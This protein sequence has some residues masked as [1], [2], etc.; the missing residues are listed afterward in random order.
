MLL[1]LAATLAP[2][3]L[4]P[5]GPTDLLTPA[6]VQA[7]G[8]PFAV[9]EGTDRD[10]HRILFRTEGD[11]ITI[12]RL[13]CLVDCINGSSSACTDCS[14]P[15]RDDF[16]VA[17]V[18]S[19]DQ[20]FTATNLRW[21]PT[22]RVLYVCGGDHGLFRLSEGA[23][24]WSLA[25]V[26][27]EP[28]TVP[29]RS[30]SL[31]CFDVDVS[32]DLVVA[33]YAG[34][35]RSVLRAY[36]QPKLLG[37]SWD[38][39]APILAREVPLGGDAFAPGGTAYAVEA[40]GQYAYVGLG[41]GGIARV[42]LRSGVVEPGPRGVGP[43][44]KIRD[45]SLAGHHLYAAAERSTG[46]GLLE[47]DLTQAWGPDMAVLSHGGEDVD[48]CAGDRQSAPYFCRVEAR[49]FPGTSDVIIA[50]A[51]H[52]R[53]V[54][55][56]EGGPYTG[57]GGFDWDL[58]V[59]GPPD[60]VQSPDV[61]ESRLYLFQRTSSGF[62]LEDVFVECEF[63]AMIPSGCPGKQL[64]F[65]LRDLLL[66]TFE[67]PQGLHRVLLMDERVHAFWARRLFGQEAFSDLVPALPPETFFTH[68]V[69]F[70]KGVASLVNP[71]VFLVGRDGGPA[72]Y[73][74]PRF[75]G[76]DAAGEPVLT[77]VEGS[78]VGPFAEDFDTDPYD[79]T[80]GLRLGVNEGAQWMD[81]R[82]GTDPVWANVE[83]H[84]GGSGTNF[85]PQWGQPE[86]VPT[87]KVTRLRASRDPL[88]PDVPADDSVLMSTLDWWLLPIPEDLWSVPPFVTPDPSCAGNPSDWTNPRGRSYS[89]FC[90]DPRPESTLFFAGRQGVPH[91]MVVLDSARIVEEV[92]R[93]QIES[94]FPGLGSG[95]E[96][97]RFDPNGLKGE[98]L[99]GAR[100]V[101]GGPAPPVQRST[102]DT[103]CWSGGQPGALA[104]I[105]R[106][107]VYYVCGGYQLPQL[108]T[109]PEVEY[110]LGQTRDIRTSCQAIG[111][112]TLQLPD[113]SGTIR[114][115]LAVASAFN[116]APERVDASG[117]LVPNELYQ[118]AQYTLFDITDWPT[119]GAP[120][121]A[122]PHVI[123]SP[124]AQGY[125]FDVGVARLDD[126]A[127]GT[128]TIL[129]GCDS[130]AGRVLA[131]DVTDLPAHFGDPTWS[132]PLAGQ[133]RV[134]P[135]VFDDLCDLPVDIA[136]D[137]D[138]STG[139]T[140]T[141]AYV[142][143]SRLG[144][145]ALELSYEPAQQRVRMDHVVTVNTPGQAVQLLIQ[146]TPQGKRA[147]LTDHEGLG[148]R[149][150][151]E[152]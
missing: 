80:N 85:Q 20:P 95:P 81:P 21:E 141:Y 5:Q 44:S 107:D 8:I 125:A 115:Y 110:D 74:L 60:G 33:I 130:S 136:V 150:Y 50:A 131:F 114:T 113:A 61:Q 129:L 140:R 133:F 59:G 71:D 48:D 86:T 148:L 43:R 139:T 97:P 91:N 65:E 38:P 137:V 132:P 40:L 53:P 22:K 55:T 11:R 29:G 102:E 13:D 78:D 72:G 16:L 52:R 68:H 57:W 36:A 127:G 93:V 82:A 134:P 64:M 42:N 6:G 37:A 128:R 58:G 25:A 106:H 1:T 51:G 56:V 109:H 126:G 67:S 116:A 112:E 146:Q 34:R 104:N 47:L 84:V 49:L 135:N 108:L 14:A 90:N 101:A 30:G 77:T 10:G 120:A 63:D 124:Y 45:L 105:T 75:A 147:L 35:D 121:Q 76:L 2:L 138:D 24:G 96:T 151:G 17:S 92:S 27:T 142:C 145:V 70:T 87:W 3:A 32:V 46:G 54:R 118:H 15:Q 99:S 18:Q 83:W 100:M 41:D 4:S 28:K 66:T 39:A 143:Y 31:W 122:R 12:W 117:A 111:M 149:A 123:N 69:T 89:P 62:S 9:A 7:A 119:Q 94:G 103:T 98:L 88:Q 79:E 23:Q 26:D 152:W 73:G 19:S 144:I